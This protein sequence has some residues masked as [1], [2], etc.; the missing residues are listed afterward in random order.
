MEALRV[1]TVCTGNICRSPLAEYF[2]R[3]ALNSEHFQLGS[4]GTHAVVDG[5]VPDQQMKIA[6][7]LGLEAISQ[8]RGR[9]ISEK[10]IRDA[11]LILTATLRHR[12]RVVRTLPSAAGKTFT[13]REFAHLSTHVREEDLLE[14]IAGQKQ[15]LRAAV[16]AV[17]LLRGTVPPP[18]EEDPYDIVDPYGENKR[19]YRKAA[20]QLVEANTA[21]SK[22]LQRVKSYAVELEA[23]H[24]APKVIEQPAFASVVPSATTA[25][26][27]GAVAATFEG[28]LP[29]RTS[30]KHSADSRDRDDARRVVTTP[31]GPANTPARGKH[32]RFGK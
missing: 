5:E 19:T 13:M 7:K 29:S 31:R 2:L 17:R 18:P 24:V 3:D 26:L 14:L 27:G 9:Q 30:G 10:D 11:D 15:D 12:R 16:T 1:L 22:F 4:A 8:H 28:S 32:R 21:I 25:T 23:A 20:E 6:G